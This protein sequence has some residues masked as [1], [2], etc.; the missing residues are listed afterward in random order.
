MLI[1]ACIVGFS[2]SSGQIYE[3]NNDGHCCEDLVLNR[4]VL[5]LDVTLVAI[6][7]K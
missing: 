3:N 4:Q 5:M 7:R 6:R 2:K 1:V